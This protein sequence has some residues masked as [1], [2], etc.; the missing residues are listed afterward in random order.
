MPDRPL[1]TIIIPTFNSGD[2]LQ[3]CL[4]SIKEQFF[5]DYE[6]VIVDGLS[7]DNTIGII[8]KN[9]EVFLNLSFISEKDEGVYD[10]MNKGIRRS[11]GKWLYFLGSD[12]R[13]MDGKVLD[14]VFKAFDELEPDIL[15][16]NVQLGVSKKIYAGEFGNG[17]IYEMNIPHQAIF[18]KREVFDVVGEFDLAYKSNAD[19]VNN[20]LWFFNPTLRKRYLN[21]VIALYS[22]S[23]LSSWYVDKVFRERK[24][25]LYLKIAGNQIDRKFKLKVLKILAINK[26]NSGNYFE[27]IWYGSV[28]FIKSIPLGVL[29]KN[30]GWRKIK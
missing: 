16:G 18:F 10:A 23:G 9:Q 4:D 6:L 15:Y 25:K 26:L 20:F 28:Y 7:I 14:N 2:N 5:T 1:L 22:E 27:F 17:K 13:L 30:I 12:D 11:N 3:D 24:E 21:I 8:K 19:W 29:L